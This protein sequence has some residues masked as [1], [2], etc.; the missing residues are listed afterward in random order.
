ML[1]LLRKL[2]VP[3]L[4][5]M[6]D[7]AEQQQAPGKP[8][9]R[10]LSS[11]AEPLALSF[12]SDAD[13]ND[14]LEV[15]KQSRP[16][17]GG[18]SLAGG[19]GGQGGGM[20]EEG[21]LTDAQK[22]KIFAFDKDLATLYTHLVPS[23]IILE[24]EFWQSH[25]KD[26]ARLLGK[27]GGKT[28]EVQRSGLSSV[29]HEV[30]RMHDGTTERVSIQLTPE[31]IEKIF[32]ER[33]EVHRAFLAHVPHSLS[34]SDFWKSYF[35]LEYKKAAKRKRLA[36]QG[37]LDVTDAD[38]EDSDDI[39]APFRRQI[40]EETAEKSRKL[41][42]TVD[43][44]VNLLAEYGDRYTESISGLYPMT[45]EKGDSYAGGV[46]ITNLESIAHDINRHGA[47]VLEGPP[48]GI[49]ITEKYSNGGGNTGA[50][51]AKEHDAGGPKDSIS[52][53]ARV[54]ESLNKAQT[55]RG[56]HSKNGKTEEQQTLYRNECSKI[57]KDRATSGLEDL[58]LEEKPNYEPL[59]ISDP[60]SYFASKS[61]A[62]GGNGATPLD[63]MN[64]E[65]LISNILVSLRMVNVES[66]RIPPCNPAHAMEATL[67]AFKEDDFG[68][69]EE[70]G[71]SAS[72][73]LLKDPRKELTGV[74]L[75]GAVPMVEKIW[76]YCF[77]INSTVSF[78]KRIIIYGIIHVAGILSLGSIENK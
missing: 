34:E 77:F 60:R 25:K 32:F 62:L 28:K 45:S 23:G 69:T 39:F 43:P 36:A 44:T 2:D 14:V 11:A 61:M 54:A 71:P 42:R 3:Q 65:K 72:T 16:A 35:K 15:I 33:P 74:M 53:A 19:D 68:L 10:I 47:Q 21:F 22:R 52:I 63:Q 56:E 8:M 70:F 37:R 30:E 75:V 24:N 13:K 6:I 57:W 4:S 5:I 38:L 78:S 1:F 48:E 17:S 26:V 51:K 41:V 9:L 64:E 40:A 76:M 31:D 12:E 49:M 73:A 46:P 67:D 29:M 59:R 66:L 27:S 18:F 58:T 7:S 55:K 20:S 50:Y